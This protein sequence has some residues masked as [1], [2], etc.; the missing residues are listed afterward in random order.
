MDEEDKREAEDAR[1]LHTSDE[2][3]GFGTEHDS[4]RKSATIDIFRP[5]GETIGSKL[6][7]RMGWR[8]GQGIGPRVKRAANLGDNQDEPGE[9]HFFAPDDV[10][11]VSLTRKRDYKGLGYRGELQGTIET[12]E[13]PSGNSQTILS[14]NESSDEEQIGPRLASSKKLSKRKPKSGFGVGV[15]ND[16]GSDDEDP[17][18]MG[19]SISYARVIGGDKRHKNKPKTKGTLGSVNP[20][21]KSKHT[22]I[23]KKLV[24]LKGALRKCHDGR[25]PLD[26]FVLADELDAFGTMTL[27]DDKYKPPEVPP[28]WKSSVSKEKEAERESGF[29]STADAAR[30]SNASGVSLWRERCRRSVNWSVRSL[31][32][33][34][35]NRSPAA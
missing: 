34:P 16:D 11:T 24:G 5:S 4:M 33:T 26:G 32:R 2:F 8:E 15:L 12:K 21:L 13:T 19:P 25:L 28:D 6:L 1:T 14:R 7:K 3:A 22:F 29:V 31:V 23:S 10:P 27:Q 30:L 20:S 9:M 18:S 35:D 17:Y